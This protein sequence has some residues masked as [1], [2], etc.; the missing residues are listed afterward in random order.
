MYIQKKCRDF[1]S[2]L[3]NLKLAS[4]ER[5]AN[6]INPFATCQRQVKFTPRGE[7]PLLPLHSFKHY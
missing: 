2:A 4:S 6:Q 3:Q 5:A 7:Y 1:L